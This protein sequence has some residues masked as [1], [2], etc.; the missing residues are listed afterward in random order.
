VDDIS[1]RAGCVD[2]PIEQRIGWKLQREIVLLLAW[3]PAILL[4]LAHPLVA[5]G[6]ADHSSFRTQRRGRTR[7]L[8]H[9]I[10]AMLQLCFGTEAEAQAT[11]ARINAIHDRVNGH[12]AGT[13]GVFPAGTPYSAHDPALLA[14]VHATLLD[15]NLRVYERYVG[16]LS[17]DEKDRYCAE[18]SA[19]ETPFAIPAGRL[20]RSFD[21]LNRYMDAMLASGEIAVSEDARLLA[22]EILYPPAPRLA[23]PALVLVRLHTVGLLPAS[24]RAAYGLSWSARRQAAMTASTRLV[25]AALRFTPSVVRHW[26]AARRAARR[27]LENGRPR[28]SA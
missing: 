25:R 7:R 10:D 16:P 27:I 23:A 13:A 9:T 1:A 24:I 6:I 17:E 15:M 22:R 20:P 12:L 5:Q 21:E 8:L 3:A 18:A 28:A 26:P 11:L 2:V 14:W 4:Q 19:I